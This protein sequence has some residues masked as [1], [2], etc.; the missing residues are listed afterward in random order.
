MQTKIILGFC[1]ETKKVNNYTEFSY[2]EELMQAKGGKVNELPRDKFEK[3]FNEFKKDPFATVRPMMTQEMMSKSIPGMDGT[4]G[5]MMKKQEKQYKDFF[6]ATDNSIE[7]SYGKVNVGELEKV[8][9]E[10]DKK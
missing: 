6:N 9:K 1:R 7:P 3:K 5:D 8:G 2:I 4:I 10:G